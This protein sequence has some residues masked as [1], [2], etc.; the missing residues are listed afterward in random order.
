MQVL[1]Q[2]PQFQ[3]A[4]VLVGSATGDDAGVYRLDR[5]RALV[6]TVDFFTPIVDDPFTYGQIAATN[7]LSDIYAMG[8][9]PITAMNLMGVPTDLVPL[10]TINAILRGGASRAI[11]ARCSIVGG[12]TIRNPEPFYGLS[13]TG[14]VNPRR[15]ITNASGKAGDV[16]VL[17]NIPLLTAEK[18]N[19]AKRFVTLI[20]ALYEHKVKLI[21][22]AAALPSE[23]YIQGH[24][25]F[26]FERTVSRLIEMQS[27]TYM[28][29][30]KL[31]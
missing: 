11:E 2:L 20:D 16:L 31:Q 25:S 17:T 26:E 28:K 8:G 9:R 4:K 29:A 1:H 27:K 3:N 22:T 13:V 19:E 6:Q 5:T 24:G 15:M 12:H 14:L 23:L 7:S 18:R 10:K 21:A 30:A